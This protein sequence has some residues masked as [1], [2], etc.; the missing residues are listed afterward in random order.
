MQSIDQLVYQLTLYKQC[1]QHLLAMMLQYLTSLMVFHVT[2][3]RHITYQ[4]D[5]HN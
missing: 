5:K 4:C 3:R 2:E 1:H